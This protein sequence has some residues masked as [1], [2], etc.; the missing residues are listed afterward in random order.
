MPRVSLKQAR[1][2]RITIVENA[3]RLFLERGFRNIPLSEV[4]AT[5]GLTL[6]GFYGHFESRDALANEACTHAFDLAIS[7][8]QQRIAAHRCKRSAHQSIIAQYLRAGRAD[9]GEN[10]CPLV[11]FSAEVAQEPSD[12]PIHQTYA[13]GL[14]SLIQTYMQTLETLDGSSDRA[15]LKATALL[16]YSLMVGAVT[17]ARA[18]RNNPLSE[19]ILQVARDYLQA[20]DRPTASHASRTLRVGAC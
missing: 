16:Q 12:S 8:W 18:A 15:A 20:D 1:L 19:E 5:A 3:A 2:N 7:F 4:M 10:T 11:A 14:E 9:P 6:G 13:K 17:L